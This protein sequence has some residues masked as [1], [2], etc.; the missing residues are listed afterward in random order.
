M[1]RRLYEASARGDVPAFLDLIKEDEELIKQTTFR[2]SN[3]VL[4]I[5]TKFGHLDLATEIV[6]I[7]PE[8]VSAV[9]ER[10][11]TPLHEACREGHLE[12]MKLMLRTDP[13]VAYKL[14]I[15][16]ESVLYVACGRG[17]F[18]LVKQLLLDRSW[19][20]LLEDDRFTTSLH[21]AASAGYNDIVKE[22]LKARPEVAWRKDLQGCSPLHLA[23]SSGHLDIIREFL[24]VEPGICSLQDKDGKTPLHSAAIKGRVDILREILS[25]SL[26][27]ADMV[28][29]RG[30]T[31][32]HLAVKNNHY[33]AFR[34]LMDTL[35]ITDLLNMSDNDGNNILHLASARKVTAIVQYLVTK[36]NININAMNREGF[37]ALDVVAEASTGIESDSP[38]IRLTLQ[39]AGG[40]RSNQLFPRR[41]EIQQLT[42]RNNNPP[43]ASVDSVQDE[44]RPLPSPNLTTTIALGS[45]ANHYRPDRR[46]H[47]SGRR[48]K[49]RK[50]YM[51]GLT[52]VRNT[53]ILV[54]VLI[55]T[56]TFSSGINPPGGI[57]LETGPLIGESLVGKKIAF[58]V[59]MVCNNL[60]LFS[61]LGIVIVLVSVIPFQ[62]KSLTILVE[63]I[64]KVMWVSVSFMAAAYIA[65]I[66]IVTPSDK[67]TKWILVVVV[68]IGGGCMMSIFVGL[69]VMLTKHWLRKLDWKKKRGDGMTNERKVRNKEISPNSSVSSSECTLKK[70]KS[71]SIEDD[72]ESINSDMDSS[73]DDGI[74]PI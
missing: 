39:E 15:L 69:M 36:T 53:I 56:V 62:R 61:S 67:G 64:N 22:I 72:N 17:Q 60:A 68:S 49:Q 43:E 2:T 21:V 12:L 38:E 41:A 57:H 74:H 73:E 44:R 33:E 13:R 27:S 32:L 35:D 30:E 71:T 25:T 14:N 3:T 46:R 42:T 10:N 7:Q 59:F 52:N 48:E 9:N 47:P 50:L 18:D 24:S 55:A 70:K 19:L 11:E 16:N 8:M 51:E 4:H 20:L 5:V 1:D 37:T 45:P 6:K 58:K 63:A 65:A 28:T 26:D 23:C 66:W 29:Q 54:A 31:V 40:K 34:Y